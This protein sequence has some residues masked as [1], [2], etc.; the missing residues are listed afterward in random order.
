MTEY[1]TIVSMGAVGEHILAW[2][3]RWWL[4]GIG[5]SMI[6]EYGKVKLAPG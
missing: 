4:K 5:A 6:S 2:S 1:D 3:S